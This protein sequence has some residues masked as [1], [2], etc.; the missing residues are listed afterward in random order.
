MAQAGYRYA[1]TICDHVDRR[2]PVLTI[3]RTVF[4]EKTCVTA[5]GEFS[6]ALM[7][8]QACGA[9]ELVSP[10]CLLDHAPVPDTVVA[11]V[12]A[13]AAQRGEC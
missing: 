13:R 10:R 1:Y 7:R 11:R 4:W 9:F 3:P 6:P 12:P 2:D 5:R 8:A